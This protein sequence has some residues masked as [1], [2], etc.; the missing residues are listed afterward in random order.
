MAEF[1]LIILALLVLEETRNLALVLLGLF[2]L[3]V[4]IL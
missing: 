2:A 1:F 4:F 3:Y